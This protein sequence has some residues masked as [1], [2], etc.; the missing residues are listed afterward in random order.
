[1]PPATARHVTLPLQPTFDASGKGPSP[2]RLVDLAR[3]HLGDRLGGELDI[4]SGP[5]AL[6]GEVAAAQWAG[7][8]VTSDGAMFTSTP[9]A[10]LHPGYLTARLR[11]H[12]LDDAL[13]PTLLRLR[14]SLPRRQARCA[15]APYGPRVDEGDVVWAPVVDRYHRGVL[16]AQR[17][18]LVAA[19]LDPAAVAV[20]HARVARP[21][22]LLVGDVPTTKEDQ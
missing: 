18:Y 9:G 5:W 22:S 21:E 11:A 7:M 12:L 20:R 2:F 19:Y 10:H 15:L 16:I 1:M 17:R 6:V 8:A 13:R 4:D 14:A 3:R